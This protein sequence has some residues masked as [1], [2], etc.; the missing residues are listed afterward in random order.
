M[1]DASTRGIPAP[2]RAH[3]T[4][5]DHTD[6][7]NNGYLVFD[8]VHGMQ[9]CTL[10]SAQSITARGVRLFVASHHNYIYCTTFNIYYH[11]EIGYTISFSPFCQSMVQYEVTHECARKHQC[12]KLARSRTGRRTVSTVTPPLPLSPPHPPAPPHPS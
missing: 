6:V 7:Y 3:N 1:I 10:L 5:E 12:T 8:I 11:V 9:N 4:L 2:C